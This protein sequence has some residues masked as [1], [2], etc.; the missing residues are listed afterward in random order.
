M[1]K[2]T[3]FDVEEKSRYTIR[4]RK[5]KYFLRMLYVE[6]RLISGTAGVV[7]R[8]FVHDMCV[9]RLLFFLCHSLSSRVF[10][11]LLSVVSGAKCI[12]D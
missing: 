3:G 6:N 11:S 4:T 5:V 10:Y 8:G 9:D 1:R 7:M 2:P 12:F